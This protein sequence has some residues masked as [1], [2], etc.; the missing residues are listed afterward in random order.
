M[1]HWQIHLRFV[2]AQ[3][4]ILLQGSYFKHCSLDVQVGIRQT[5]RRAEHQNACLFSE[6]P[7]QINQMISYYNNAFCC[8]DSCHILILYE[9]SFGHYHQNSLY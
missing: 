7:R 2:C 4:D 6:M 8:C 3:L 1:L 9:L 5:K